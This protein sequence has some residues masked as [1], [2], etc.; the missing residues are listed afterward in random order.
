MITSEDLKGLSGRELRQAEGQ[1]YEQYLVKIVIERQNEIWECMP[2]HL[3]EYVIGTYNLAKKRKDES[4]FLDKWNDDI[5][6]TET[7]SIFGEIEAMENIFGKHNLEQIDITFEEL[8]D[9]Q[10]KAKGW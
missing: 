7:A 3:K 10:M 1:L 5:F 9:Q 4:S 6:S 2:E 8:V